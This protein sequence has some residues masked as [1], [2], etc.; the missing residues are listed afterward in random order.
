M[1]ISSQPTLP[2]SSPPENLHKV[3][4]SGVQPLPDMGNS[5]IRKSPLD[6]KISG[7]NASEGPSCSTET[8]TVQDSTLAYPASSASSAS[9]RPGGWAASTGRKAVGRAATADQILRD[10]T[11]RLRKTS[12]LAHHAVASARASAKEAINNARTSL[13]HRSK[14]S[15]GLTVGSRGSTGSVSSSDPSSINPNLPSGARA[16]ESSANPG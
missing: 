1:H 16:S 8:P 14:E 11:G 13:V 9:R 10:S 7:A 3:S 4:P 2:P 12:E 15:G 6:G 5:L